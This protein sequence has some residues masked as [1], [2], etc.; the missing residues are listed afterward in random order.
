MKLRFGLGCLVA[1]IL[2]S[3]A[4]AQSHAGH[5]APSADPHA[6]H[7]MPGEA[8]T[9]D[10]PALEPPG[11]HA[12]ERFYDRGVMAA[13]R[14]QL[15]REHGGQ[16]AWTVMLDTLE[17]RPDDTTY[18]WS[19]EAWYG[20]DLNRVVVKSEGEW[21]RGEDFTA[22]QAQV[23]YSRAIGP[24]F[25]LQ[26]GLRHD[27]HPGPSRTYATLGFEGL[28]PY[29]FELQGAAYLS[30]RGDVTAS[31]EAAYDLRLTQ[32][33]ILQPRAEIEA[34]LRDVPELDL[35]SGLTRAEVALRLRDEFRREFGPPS[36]EQTLIQVMI[37]PD[38]HP[39][40]FE[41]LERCRPLIEGAGASL[42]IDRS[43][44]ATD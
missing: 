10:A 37:H 19:G 38:S 16:R 11:D 43:F 39:E 33:L 40:I 23:L 3:P 14:S 22:V 8:V 24:Y 1:S 35:G 4:L 13:A 34:S 28:A 42:E 32:R 21:T 9:A 29:W 25:D 18:A 44:L 12:A 36:R 2:T 20:G 26:A 41:L 30:D 7:V 31:L 17:A 5:A 27:A 15:A 6:G